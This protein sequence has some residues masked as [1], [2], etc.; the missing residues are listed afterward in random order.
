MLAAENQCN[1]S[2]QKMAENLV[3][4]ESDFRKFRQYCREKGFDLSYHSTEIR[5]SKQQIE[6]RQSDSAKVIKLRK[7]RF[8]FEGIPY[9]VTE[10]QQEKWRCEF[11]DTKEEFLHKKKEDQR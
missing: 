9:D 6:G 7:R 3:L 11:S 4:F 10:W 2:N 1:G 5:G 8:S